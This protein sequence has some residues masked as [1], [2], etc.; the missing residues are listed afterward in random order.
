MTGLETEEDSEYI[1]CHKPK[2]CSL[3]GTLCELRNFCLRGISVW[4]LAERH[5][6]SRS[7][8]VLVPPVGGA[9]LATGLLVS[10]DHF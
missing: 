4:G 7:C 5:H 8:L 10:D 3:I 6:C 2:S 9:S 1:L